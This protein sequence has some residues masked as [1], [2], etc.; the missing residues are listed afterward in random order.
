MGDEMMRPVICKL[1]VSAA[2]GLEPS[3]LEPSGLEP[4]PYN[5]DDVYDQYREGI[6]P[7]VV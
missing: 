1:K 4:I 7:L 5:G 6:Y 3:G 2:S